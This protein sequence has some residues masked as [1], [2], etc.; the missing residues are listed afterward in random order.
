[1]IYYR[2]ESSLI[3][4]ASSTASSLTMIYYRIE[5]LRVVPRACC[6]APEG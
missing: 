5:R 3:C 2:I 1:M 4:F 6:G